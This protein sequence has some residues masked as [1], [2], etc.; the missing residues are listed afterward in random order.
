MKKFI[1]LFVVMALFGTS[2]F[3]G[4]YKSAGCGLGSMIIKDDG[5]VQIFAATT[6]GTFDSQTF[7][8]TSGTSNCGGSGGYASNDVEQKMYVS[9]NLDS[10]SQE[11]ALGSGEHLNALA[12]L[13]GCDQAAAPKFSAVMKKDYKSIVGSNATPDTLLTNVK[14]KV[15]SDPVLKNSCHS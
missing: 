7:G 9:S 2:A 1:G 6:N 4:G 12:S 11:A 3:A 15:S 13:V 8:I 5:F 14:S 10:I